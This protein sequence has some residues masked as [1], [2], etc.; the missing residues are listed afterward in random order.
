MANDY[1]EHL[2]GVAFY[3]ERGLPQKIITQA[4]QSISWT[5]QSFHI[6]SL[7]KLISQVLHLPAF[8]YGSLVTKDYTIVVVRQ[9][10]G[11]VACIQRENLIDRDKLVSYLQT[12]SPETVESHHKFVSV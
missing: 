11:Y 2:Q 9:S 3:D 7:Q 6:L 8:D 10:N 5:E 12:L 4:E 1:L